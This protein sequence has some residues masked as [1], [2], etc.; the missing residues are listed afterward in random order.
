MQHETVAARLELIVSKTETSHTYNSCTATCFTYTRRLRLR[1]IRVPG[2]LQRRFLCGIE[3]DNCKSREQKRT[4]H[5]QV[6]TSLEISTNVTTNATGVQLIKPKLIRNFCPLGAYQFSRRKCWQ[7]LHR[8]VQ[9]QCN[10]S[11]GE[12]IPLR[13]QTIETFKHKNAKLR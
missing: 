2:P 5:Q 9:Q 10:G 7:V 1:S 11:C 8:I 13:C 4:H 6:H 12:W 3:Q